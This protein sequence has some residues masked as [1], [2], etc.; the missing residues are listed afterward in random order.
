MGTWQMV[1]KDGEDIVFK[2]LD[3]ALKSG[4]RMF[5]TASAYKNE[6]DI[7]K[8]L[9]ILLPKYGLKRSDIFITSKL[10]PYDQGLDT[11]Y[12]ACLRSIE[13]IGY[14]YLDL[15]LI[16]WP[17]A[18]QLKREDPVNLTRRKESWKALEK[19]LREGRVKSIGVSNYT[20]K[21]LEEMKTYSTVLPA[22]NQ[23][24]YHPYLNQKT[25]LKYCKDN[26]IAMQAYSSLGIGKLVHDSV[27]VDIGKKYGK[28]SA[29][30]LYR[31]AIEHDVA[32]LPKSTNSSHIE[33]N[34]EIFA[35][36]LSPEDMITLDNMDKN[37]H[38]CW[39]PNEVA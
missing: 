35:F 13:N 1:S 20:V 9:K 21:H 38:F 17:G 16:H 31:W 27:F 6:E 15:Y 39:N 3:S 18:A 22:V 26:N 32:I 2:A 8:S 29:Q 14:E 24:E 33:Q 34:M 28:T 12:S 37:T 25:L 10:A 7:G 36:T 11:A 4:Y 23:V 30:V 5:D 19:L